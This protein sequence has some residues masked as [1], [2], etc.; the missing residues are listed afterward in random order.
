MNISAVKQYYQFL[1]NGD[2][3]KA[4]AL[5]HQDVIWH[6]PGSTSVSGSHKGKQPVASLLAKFAGLGLSIELEE[7]YRLDDNILCRIIVQHRIGKRHEF[8]LIKIDDDLISTI[9]H[10]GDTDYLSAVFSD[11]Q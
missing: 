1:S 8:Q 9:T 11:Q 5:L 7:A 2:A 3:P 6:Q 4:V 10:Y